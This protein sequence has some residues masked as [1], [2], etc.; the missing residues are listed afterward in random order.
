MGSMIEIAASAGDGSFAAYIAEPSGS[1]HAAIVVI[2]EIFGVNPGIRAKCDSLAQLGYLAVAPDLFWRMQPG[3]QLDPDRPEEL[4]Q[5]FDFVSRIRTD[6]ALADVATTIRAARDR[7]GGGKV[8]VVGYCFGGKVA[9]LAATRTD[10]DATVSYYGGGIDALVG[11]AHGIARPLMLHFAGDDSHIT[12]DKLAT[13]HGALDGHPR[14]T[15]HEYPGADH[16]FAT[17]FG[18]RRNDAAATQADART[19]EFFRDHLA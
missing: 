11:E 14:V 15:I 16:G 1:P 17:E 7:I 8:G 13:I 2:Q 10:T 12:P 19:A 9:F 4:K 18:K 5:A 6:D 3:V